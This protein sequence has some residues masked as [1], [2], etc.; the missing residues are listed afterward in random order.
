M[1]E[2]YNVVGSVWVLEYFVK[3]RLEKR[4]FND[5]VRLMA[6]LEGLDEV[7][8]SA[9]GTICW[10]VAERW[11]FRGT[12]NF[13]VAMGG[14]VVDRDGDGGTEVSVERAKFKC[15]KSGEGRVELVQV[16]VSL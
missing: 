8:G 2:Q 11:V 13:L 15:V 5:G 16:Y 9:E 7:K 14:A 4:F 12:G 10:A 1:W 3:G 6:W